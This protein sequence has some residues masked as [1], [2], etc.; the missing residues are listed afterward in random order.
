[1]SSHL[2]LVGA[3]AD[4][5]DREVLAGVRYGAAVVV[6]A[7]PQRGRRLRWAQLLTEGPSVPA[8]PVV[9]AL[10]RSWGRVVVLGAS[11]RGGGT[12]YVHQHEACEDDDQDVT[13]TCAATR[14]GEEQWTLDG[15]L[16][17]E[18]D[19]L[20]VG[21]RDIAGA[22]G[23]AELAAMHRAAAA[24]GCGHWPRAVGPARKSR[25]PIEVSAHRVGEGV[26]PVPIAVSTAQ[27][28]PYA[29]DVWDCGELEFGLDE[30]DGGEDEL[31]AVREAL[32]D[33]ITREDGLARA[34]A[35]RARGEMGAVSA[36]IATLKAAG[37]WGEVAEAVLV[38]ADHS[39]REA[40]GMAVAW[41]AHDLSR[42]DLAAARAAVAA[43][44]ARIPDLGARLDRQPDL[45]KLR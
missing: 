9:E 10:A 36:E 2:L 3:P 4:A 1:V 12:T 8:R 20:A 34:R 29:L 13:T 31:L 25:R 7:R 38:W 17:A 40:D 5:S 37:R 43:A 15:E 18:A 35:L 42:Y 44:V 14:I 39:E 41:V 45:A 26:G 6:L 16:P 21:F 33:R 28:L 30:D 22:K 23:A 11:D 24:L 19:V 32:R 27:P